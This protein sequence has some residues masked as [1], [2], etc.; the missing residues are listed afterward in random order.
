[1]P[2]NEVTLNGGES[3][4]QVT[5]PRIRPVF[6]WLAWVTLSGLFLASVVA[7]WSAI[8]AIPLAVLEATYT[9]L[10]LHWV[11]VLLVISACVVI[12][13]GVMV[14]T[15]LEQ[16]LAIQ[17]QQLGKLNQLIRNTRAVAAKI[18]RLGKDSRPHN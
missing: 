12:R 18:D 15:Y 14:R 7:N 8:I 2:A 16:S 9:W 13:F 3:R 6:K 17:R 5:K 1:M 11:A 10:T 4:P